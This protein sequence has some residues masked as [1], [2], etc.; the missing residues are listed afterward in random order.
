MITP[1]NL[2]K[3]NLITKKCCG[4]KEIKNADQFQRKD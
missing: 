1:T 3:Q 4:C 2:E